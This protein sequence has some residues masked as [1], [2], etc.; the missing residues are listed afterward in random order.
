MAEQPSPAGT[1]PTVS[2]AVHQIESSSGAMGGPVLG[3]IWRM[4]ATYRQRMWLSIVLGVLS[5]LCHLLPPAAAAGIAAALLAGNTNLAVYWALAMLGASLAAVVLFAGST[6]VSHYIAADMQHDQRLKIAAKLRRV[7]LGVF[8][9]L[10]PAALRRILIDDIEKL[11]DGIAHLIPE[12]TAAFV[13]PL[14][15]LAIMAVLD[16]R[17]A[18]AA[19]LP[20]IGGFVFMSIIMRKAV[21]PVN[22]FNKAQSEIALSMDEVVRAIPVVK[23]Y[24]NADSALRRAESAIGN[25]HTVIAGFITFSV[26]PSNWLFLCATSNLL[27]LTPLSLVLMDSGAVS[28][29][30]VIFFHLGAM[31]LALL[32]SG[33]F[34]ISNR[35][36]A[37]E[38]VIARWLALMNQPEQHFSET[39]PQPKGADIAFE[40]VQFSYGNGGAA[41]SDITLDVPG[42]TTLALVGPSGA[43]KSTLARLLAR[44]W[45][46]DSGRI[47]LGGVDLRDLDPATHAAHLSFV[48]QEVFLFSRS[49]ADNI[50]MGRPEA[51]DAEIET[52]AR[53]ACAHDFITALPHGYETVLG[54]Q[55]ALSLG[56]QQRIAIARALLHDAPVLVLD[57]AT[58]FAD[59]ESEAELQRAI[60]TLARGRT[61]IV[62]AHRLSSIRNANQ[63]A[64]LD[65]GRVVELGTH[66]ALLARAGIY[67]AQWQAHQDARSF[68]LSNRTANP[69]NAAYLPNLGAQQA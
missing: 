57:E 47:T 66:D 37:Q 64:V 30:L 65:G 35:M 56:Q 52:A 5:A 16:W 29:P 68:T 14:S 48:F 23:T 8:A 67:A 38:G 21:E 32:M 6:M 59:P 51:T 27:L 12:L 55:T 40:K 45:D 44:F 17:L 25:F 9:H 39:G 24:N 43:G 41:L 49:V 33:L 34:G 15:M 36:R 3:V 10:S 69:D 13:A 19:T 26:V 2:D 11:E 63:I 58:A 50:R 61:L 42:G 4:I 20:T 18:L 46:P 31:S 54:S 1:D 7:P 22:A 62:I 28:L 53:A 60:S